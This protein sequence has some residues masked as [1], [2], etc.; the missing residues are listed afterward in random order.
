MLESMRDDVDIWE[1]EAENS[2]NLRRGSLQTTSSAS[3]SSFVAPQNSA[4]AKKEC[5]AFTANDRSRY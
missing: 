5:V 3:P 4:A 2:S 1:E